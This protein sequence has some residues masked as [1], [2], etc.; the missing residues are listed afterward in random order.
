MTSRGRALVFGASGYVGSSLVPELQRRGYS[1]RAAAPSRESLERR[2]WHDV[3]CIAADAMDF[4]SLGPAMDDVEVA[5]YLVHSAGDRHADP[6]A[7]LACAGNF[8]RA[9]ADAGVSRI[10]YLGRLIPEYARAVHLVSRKETGDRL[11]RGPVPVTEIR[12]G[13]IVG[14][15]SAAFEVVRDLVNHLPVMLT[16]RWV[17][18]RT[19][20]IA[21]DNLLTYLIEVAAKPEAAGGIYD[22]AGPETLSCE[23]MMRVYADIAGRRTRILPVPVM[24]PFLSSFWVGLFTAVPTSVARALIGE[25][26][27]DMVADDA[28]LRALVPLRLLDFREAVSRSL[29][30]ERQGAVASRWTEGAFMFRG[31]R[32]DHSWYAKKAEGEALTNAPIEE[33]WR[34]VT[35]IGGENRY[36]YLNFLWT[37]RE[38]MD[39]MVGGPGLSHGRRQP[40]DVRVGDSIDSWQVVGV[41]ECRR[42]TLL[43][44]MKAPGAGVLEFELAPV[45][46]NVRV[47]AT[48]YFHPAGFLGLLYWWSLFLPHLV[49]FDG[50]TSSIARRAESAAQGQ[51][52]NA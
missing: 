44:G 21:L 23:S 29:D 32:H 50:L 9:A 36:Y 35:A 5:Y 31:Y 37:I 33:V 20:P 8:A 4:E 51:P 45:G 25:L 2:G 47:K 1:V 13:V 26:E 52:A 41:E 10:V 17:R 7:E 49:I 11:R 39:W 16:P 46:E 15:G 22:A 38:I 34:Q 14:P 6:R 24:S 18:S 30:I 19:Q 42:L 27:Q 43:F 48:A 3:D 28:A 12:A 40:V